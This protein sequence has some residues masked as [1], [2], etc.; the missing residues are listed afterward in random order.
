MQR[1]VTSRGGIDSVEPQNHMI[2]GSSKDH[3]GTVHK[4]NIDSSFSQLKFFN[5]SYY[6]GQSYCQFDA[7]TENEDEGPFIRISGYFK[8]LAA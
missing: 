8:V 5:D 6:G 4:A 7:V 1:V 2:F 3:N